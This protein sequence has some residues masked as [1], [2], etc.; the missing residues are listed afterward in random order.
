[1]A[2]ALFLA[3]VRADEDREAAYLNRLNLSAPVERLMKALM[4]GSASLAIE[5]IPIA[6]EPLEGDEL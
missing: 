1:M 6:F 2:L 5:I 3:A 4:F